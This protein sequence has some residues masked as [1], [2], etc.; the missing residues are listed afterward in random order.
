MNF[1]PS[2]EKE[3]SPK[4]VM[5]LT[6]GGFF[7]ILVFPALDHRFAWSPVPAYISI[8][9]DILLLLS[10]LLFLVVFKEDTYGACTLRVEEGHKVF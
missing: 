3:T 8:A 9:G 1:G 10:F 7:A 4:I 2:A 6:M 5:V